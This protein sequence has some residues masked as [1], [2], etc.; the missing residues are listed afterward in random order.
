MTTNE[1]KEDP[2]KTD[3]VN[4]AEDT[5]N[6]PAKKSS[7]NALLIIIIVLVV[8][9]GGMYMGFRFIS[10]KV[11]EKVG[12]KSA[13]KVLEGITG[14]NVD[15]KNG[16]ED[17]TIKTKDGSFSTSTSLPKGFPSDFPVYDNAKVTA[18][19][20]STQESG[21]GSYVTFETTDSAS[22]VSS[23]YKTELASNG[24][25]T[26]NESTYGDLTSFTAEKG[27]IQASVS[28]SRDTSSEKTTIVVTISEKSN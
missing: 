27:T 19:I 12:E 21:A 18:S 4:K 28:I 9:F 24:W 14:G 10:N 7:S 6:Q 16:G 25:E 20:A 17:V 11:S 5:K 22:K 2:K 15:I 23:F 26:S 3:G 1:K 8:L 13:E